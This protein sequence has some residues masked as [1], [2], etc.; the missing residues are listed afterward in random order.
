M[1]CKLNRVKSDD[2]QEHEILYA[3]CFAILFVVFTCLVLHLVRSVFIEMVE[4]TL[5]NYHFTNETNNVSKQTAQVELNV[6]VAK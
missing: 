5:G 3:K 6:F 2:K 4:N 1:D